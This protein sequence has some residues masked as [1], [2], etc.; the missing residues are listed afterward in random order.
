MIGVIAQAYEEAKVDN[1]S[2]Y[3]LT[4]YTGR[5]ISDFSNII[6]ELTKDDFGE[7]E[8]AAAPVQINL[9]ASR[10]TEEEYDE[11]LEEEPLRPVDQTEKVDAPTEQELHE[12]EVREEVENYVDYAIRFAELT[13]VH[14]TDNDDQVDEKQA[15]KDHTIKDIMA[16]K[17]K[18]NEAANIDT[19]TDKLVDT[20]EER[21]VD[22]FIDGVVP[23]TKKVSDDVIKQ[24]VMSI[25]TASSKAVSS[26]AQSKNQQSDQINYS[27]IDES[28]VTD[29][30]RKYHLG[31]LVTTSPFVIP[32]N[33]R[34]T[35]LGPLDLTEESSPDGVGGWVPFGDKYRYES[36]P[37]PATPTAEYTLDEAILLN[38]IQFK[39]WRGAEI[40]KLANF[41]QLSDFV[42]NIPL[43]LH[44]STK[45][46]RRYAIVTEGLF[47]LNWSIDS[48]ILF[49]IKPALNSSRSRKSAISLL[50]LMRDKPKDL[51]KSESDLR[52][53]R[54]LLRKTTDGKLLITAIRVMEN[55]AYDDYQ[56]LIPFIYLIC[57][58]ELDPTTDMD[59]IHPSMYLKYPFI[60][61]MDIHN[62]VT[63]NLDGDFYIETLRHYVRR[64][65]SGAAI[66]ETPS[67]VPISPNEDPSDFQKIERA[68]IGKI[69]RSRNI[70]KPKKKEGSSEIP[71]IK[72]K[73]IDRSRKRMKQGKRAK[74]KIVASKIPQT[75]ASNP[76]TGKD[77]TYDLLDDRQIAELKTLLE[78]HTDKSPEEIIGRMVLE[79]IIP[80]ITGREQ[81]AYD[82]E[83]LTEVIKNFNQAGL[84]TNTATSALTAKLY[85]IQSSW[86]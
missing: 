7:K 14:D 33:Q 24:A 19:F 41:E 40:D 69:S 9:D 78:S 17:E 73:K 68:N 59:L 38:L 57:K 54:K 75:S 82:A 32:L 81:I 25:P 15:S 64:L 39:L 21:T 43:P 85:T 18:F 45:K 12:K 80:S 31:P 49:E 77:S 51:F 2:L 50:K 27:V 70:I 28:F 3:D 83:T 1:Y 66:P 74:K 23:H 84:K 8:V 16:A 22:K 79:G 4:V 67:N 71:T 55:Y 56:H 76:L 13:D 36:I 53:L 46:L 20:E 35:N 52:R 30:V 48:A 5:I 62:F 29:T 37:V 60:E 47:D 34:P 42:L 11:Y 10:M 86:E 6:T 63:A 44:I 65:L 61:N 26:A 72:A 58:L